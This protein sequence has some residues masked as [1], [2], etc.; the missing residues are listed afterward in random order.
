MS[1]QK[2]FPQHYTIQNWIQ[3]S[4]SN[5]PH[6]WP[7]P[8]FILVWKFRTWSRSSPEGPGKDQIVQSEMVNHKTGNALLKSLSAQGSEQLSI[9]TPQQPGCF[10]LQPVK[11]LGRQR[12]VRTWHLWACFGPWTL[13]WDLVIG[14][15]D[16]KPSPTPLLLMHVCPAWV[17]LRP[18]QVHPL[19]VILCKEQSLNTSTPAWHGG[20][21]SHLCGCRMRLLVEWTSKGK[22]LLCPKPLSFLIPISFT[23]CSCSHVSTEPHCQSLL[24][25]IK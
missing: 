6:W 23:V 12:W 1:L 24:L 16:K 19:S 17:L 4:C 20:N 13:L 25:Q 5:P 9:H 22:D 11:G 14:S 7:P 8:W 2:E 10:R 3:Q 15:P 18:H 21:T